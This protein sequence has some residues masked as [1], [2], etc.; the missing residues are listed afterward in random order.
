MCSTRPDLAC[1]LAPPPHATSPNRLP[2]PTSPTLRSRS[3]YHTN[4]SPLTPSTISPPNILIPSWP[5]A[6]LPLPQP[7]HL[8]QLSTLWSSLR[9]CSPLLQPSPL[10]QHPPQSGQ[11]M[12]PHRIFIVSSGLVTCINYV[13]FSSS[14]AY[15]QY[16]PT[17]PLTLTPFHHSILPPPLIC[18]LQKQLNT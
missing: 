12:P 4:L 7:A 3:P 15:S 13:C 1:S 11:S 14:S 6:W 17:L 18:N 8:L 9:P 16:S 10:L 2:L 5:A